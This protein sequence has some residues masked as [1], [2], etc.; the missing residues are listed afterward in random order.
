MQIHTIYYH[1]YNFNLL[2]FPRTMELWRDR[3]MVRDHCPIF[4]LRHTLY[5]LHMTREMCDWDMGH[6]VPMVRMK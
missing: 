5:G 4:Y 3:C 2:H 1:A 6:L